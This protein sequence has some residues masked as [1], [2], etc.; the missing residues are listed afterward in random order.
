[1]RAGLEEFGSRLER[2]E[3]RA[4]EIIPP[5]PVS[6]GIS[7]IP[8]KPPALCRVVQRDLEISVAAAFA[9]E[10]GRFIYSVS[11]RRL[12]GADGEP[13]LGAAAR[14]FD[15]CQLRGRGRPR[16]VRLKCVAWDPPPKVGHH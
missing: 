14:G 12:C 8:A 6:R 10:L 4:A 2:G 13:T 9:P 3:Y 16:S 5:H 1:M 11:S 15:D 7:L